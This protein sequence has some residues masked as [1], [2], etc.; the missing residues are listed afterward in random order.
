MIL[1][2][3]VG[4]WQQ[5]DTIHLA[6]DWRIRVPRGPWFLENSFGEES[7]VSHIQEDGPVEKIESLFLRGK[8]VPA[9]QQ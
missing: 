6:I 1:E 8:S 3:P 7:I 4:G 2:V 5:T 9:D